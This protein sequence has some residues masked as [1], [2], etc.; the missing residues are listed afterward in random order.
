MKPLR[1]ITRDLVAR[2]AEAKCGTSSPSRANRIIALIR[3]VLRRAEFEWEW[4][5]KA[6]KLR[7]YPEPKRRVR[8]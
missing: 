4:L 8:G 1:E 6:P 3:A 5:D 2:I 7:M